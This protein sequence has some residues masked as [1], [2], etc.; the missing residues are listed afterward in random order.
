MQRIS[1]KNYSETRAEMKETVGGPKVTISK[2]THFTSYGLLRWGCPII[3]PRSLSAWPGRLGLWVGEFWGD[4][5]KMV[6]AL[7]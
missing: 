3:I 6:D 7:E 1:H 2:T 5:A 4:A